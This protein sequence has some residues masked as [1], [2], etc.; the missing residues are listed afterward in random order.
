MFP[1]KGLDGKYDWWR[2]LLGIVTVFI[3]YFTGQIVMYAI[4]IMNATDYDAGVR[5]L[6]SFEKTMTFDSLGMPKNL[7]FILLI[8]CFIWATFGLYI[9]TKYF[10]QKKFTS[11]ITPYQSISFSRIFFGFILWFAISV[12][13]EAVNYFTDPA[14]YTFR[15]D[16]SAFLPLVIV[17]LL[18]L[19]VQ[20][21]FEELFFRGYVLQ[22]VYAAS[23]NKWL[24]VLISSVLFGLVHGMNPEVEQYGFWTMQTYYVLAGLFLA[25]VTIMDD[26]LELALGVHAATNIFGATLFTYEGSALQTD[27]LFITHKVDPVLM[28]FA[29]VIGALIFMAICKYKYNWA[30]WQHIFSK[31]DNLPE[32]QA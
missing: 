10:H 30:S 1:S 16:I 5:A 13:L 26:R 19:P 28:T 29:F 24:A 23:K 25:I 18:F 4:V 21:S 7:V 14:N 3:F 20:T 8:S 6:E 17:S 15:F 11:L 9:V 12:S 32:T 27:S 22:G 31:H 2:Y